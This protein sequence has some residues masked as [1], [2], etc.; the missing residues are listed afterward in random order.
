[1]NVIKIIH[2]EYK[3]T[4]I[5]LTTIITDRDTTLIHNHG[6]TQGL[7]IIIILMAILTVTIHRTETTIITETT[8]TTT[9]I[10]V[11]IRK[12]P[13]IIIAQIRMKTD[14]LIEVKTERIHNVEITQETITIVITTIDL[15]SRRSE[16][17]DQSDLHDEG[18][19]SDLTAN[20]VRFSDDT[21]LP[22]ISNEGNAEAI[23][24]MR[25]SN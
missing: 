5:T 13:I 1:M 2:R 21:E 25:N 7:I 6:M 8:T 24:D 9:I 16:R 12:D 17:I 15:E 10:M 14:N 23:G 18:I 22:R 20:N 4:M 19:D 11:L 3:I